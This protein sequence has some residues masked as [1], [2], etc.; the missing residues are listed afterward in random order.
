ME[1]VGSGS[2]INDYAGLEWLHN[3]YK[4]GKYVL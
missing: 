4:M 1:N 3:Y 2:I